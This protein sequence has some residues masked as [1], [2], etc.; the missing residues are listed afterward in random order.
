MI[1]STRMRPANPQ[2]HATPSPSTLVAISIFLQ[3]ELIHAGK[4][5][6]LFPFEGMPTIEV[7][8]ET[9]AEHIPIMLH[10]LRREF[11]TDEFQVVLSEE[12]FD[13]RYGQPTLLNVE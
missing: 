2:S 11:E 5:V 8:H 7:A 12:G 9:I 10:E 13:F 4:G 6:G 3:P 1:P